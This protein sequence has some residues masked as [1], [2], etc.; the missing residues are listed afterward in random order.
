MNKYP[1]NKL[2]FPKFDREQRRTFLGMMDGSDSREWQ[3]QDG[4][5]TQSCAVSMM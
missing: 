5:I 2:F 4:L 1:E 3:Y